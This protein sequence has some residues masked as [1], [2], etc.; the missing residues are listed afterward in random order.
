[1]P[2]RIKERQKYDQL[3]ILYL[4]K[5]YFKGH[6]KRDILRARKAERFFNSHLKAEKKNTKGSSCK[7]KGNFSRYKH[8]SLRKNEQEWKV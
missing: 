2:E 3:R 8:G 1:M 6:W 7:L 5:I 4:I